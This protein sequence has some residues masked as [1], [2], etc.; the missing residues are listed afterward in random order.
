[1]LRF[2]CSLLL[3][4]GFTAFSFAQNTGIENT[5]EKLFQGMLNGDSTMV[6]ASFHDDV[7]MYTTF[8]DDKGE[9]QLRK[10][11][12]SSFLNAVGSPHEE[13]WNEVI[14]NLKIEVDDGL[15]QAWMNYSFYVGDKF[16]HC[17]VNT[18]Q[19]INVGDQWKILHLIDTRRKENCND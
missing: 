4:I 17:G 12:L 19:L 14:S 6:H 13:V 2:A 16:S 7:S 5:I 11:S 10:G 8:I 9:N 1:M 18:M 3:V 15:A